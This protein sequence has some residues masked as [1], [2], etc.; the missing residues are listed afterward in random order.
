MTKDKPKTK[1]TFSSRYNKTKLSAETV[2]VI[3]K[4]LHFYQTEELNMERNAALNLLTATDDFF[5]ILYTQKKKREHKKKVELPQTSCQQML[6]FKTVDGVVGIT[7]N[8][9]HSKIKI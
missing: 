6:G 8:T 3:K 7:P 2:T 5:I 4:A 1:D 9:L